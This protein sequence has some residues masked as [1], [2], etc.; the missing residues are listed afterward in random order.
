L[1]ESRD[2][3]L[4]CDGYYVEQEITIPIR[5]AVRTADDPAEPETRTFNI[6][7]L[8]DPPGPGEDKLDQ[9]LRWLIDQGMQNVAWVKPR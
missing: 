3:L 9:L 2:W 5:S 4:P 6:R 8:V 7:P 1:S